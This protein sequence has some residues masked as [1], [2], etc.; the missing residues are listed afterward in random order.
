MSLELLFNPSAFYIGVPKLWAKAAAL[1]SCKLLDKVHWQSWAQ[2]PHLELMQLVFC[3]LLTL[4]LSKFVLTVLPQS[5]CLLHRAGKCHGLMLME[6]GMGEYK[7]SHHICLLWHCVIWLNF[8]C[9]CFVKIFSVL[10]LSAFLV[11]SP[12]L[13]ILINS[14]NK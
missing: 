7:F 2:P 9:F 8:P 6:M 14:I 12:L 3:L 5:S 4:V 1:L 11:G 13:N 10:L